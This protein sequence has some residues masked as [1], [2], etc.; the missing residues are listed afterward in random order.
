M[1]FCHKPTEPFHFANKNERLWETFLNYVKSVKKF[2]SYKNFSLYF[3][4]LIYGLKNST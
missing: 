2:E 1:I 4:N 3:Y